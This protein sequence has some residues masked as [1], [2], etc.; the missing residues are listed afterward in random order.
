MKIKITKKISE[1]FK[2]YKNKFNNQENDI[3]GKLF[4]VVPEEV[5]W[6]YSTNNEEGYDGNQ[7]QIGIKQDGTI[8]WAYFSHCS[9]FGYEDFNGEYKELTDENLIHTRKTYEME[10][11]DTEALK[12]IKKRLK[13]ISKRGLKDLI[14]AESEVKNA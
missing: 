9:C 4:W 6:L 2:S 3:V 1:H 7:T 5:L 14:P 8:V 10:N 11:V 13:E 12:I